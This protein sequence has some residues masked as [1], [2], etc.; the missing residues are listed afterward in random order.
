M[1]LT[2]ISKAAAATNEISAPKS[3]DHDEQQTTAIRVAAALA[4]NCFFC[5]DV[6]GSISG[7]V[8]RLSEIVVPNRSWGMIALQ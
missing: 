6:A 8:Q 3:A 4:R 7:V 1:V 2:R 5:S